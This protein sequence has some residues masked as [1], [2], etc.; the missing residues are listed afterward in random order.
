M[1]KYLV[2]IALLLSMRLSSAEFVTINIPREYLDYFVEQCVENK[3]S[4][5]VTYLLVVTES[6]W[7]WNAKSPINKN[8]SQDFGL[9]QHNNFCIEWFAK[10]YNTGVMYDPMNWKD[11]LRIG[12][13]HFAYLYRTCG[14]YYDAV[15]SY[16]LGVFGYKGYL[17]RKEELPI[18]T[19]QKLITIFGKY[20]VVNPKNLPAVRT[21]VNIKNTKKRSK[22]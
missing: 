8:G 10:Q 15:A 7:K 6:E 3:V 17:A 11:N 21:P 14:N 5:Y 20:C 19:Q 12:I 9:M 22:A 2:I 1:K 13:L 18:R 16:N 4:I